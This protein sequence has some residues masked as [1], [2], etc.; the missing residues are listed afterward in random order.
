[1]ISYHTGNGNLIPL[2]SLADEAKEVHYNDSTTQI[3]ED[4]VQS[5][6]E[7]LGCTYFATKFPG[8]VPFVPVVPPVSSL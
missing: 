6:I 8:W 4:N 3:G 5:V 1:M 7:A 2:G